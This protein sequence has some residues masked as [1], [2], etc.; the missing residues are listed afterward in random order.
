MTLFISVIFITI[1]I[2]KNTIPA[3]FLLI[4]FRYFRPS[5]DLNMEIA[6]NVAENKDSNI[7]RISEKSTRTDEKKSGNLLV[8]Q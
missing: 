5:S 8:Q 2:I 1:V 7:N 3:T 4:Y 6:Q